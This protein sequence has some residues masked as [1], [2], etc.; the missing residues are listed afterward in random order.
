[1]IYLDTS[2]LTKLL[3][4]E[5]ETPELQNWLTTQN[6]QGEY[7]VTSA[8][9]RVEL[10]RVVARYGQPG[11][12]ERARYLLDGLDIVPLAEPVIALAETIGPV[13]LR[14]LDA[15]HLAAASQIKR[16]LRA[17]VTYDH[18]LLDGCRAVGLATASPGAAVS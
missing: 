4:A 18:R 2:A 15:I 12:A 8:L 17:F 13:S 16:E 10:M 1:M 9:G 7:G 6:G 14:S 11:H 3:I 5:P